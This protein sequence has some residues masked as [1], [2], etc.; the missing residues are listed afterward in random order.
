[1]VE[2]LHATQVGGEGSGAGLV[3]QQKRTLE[4]RNTLLCADL[5]LFGVCRKFHATVPGHPT[6]TTGMC[7]CS[8]APVRAAELGDALP[9]GIIA[10]PLCRSGR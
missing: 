10:T 4:L 5:C 6:L 7:G 1:V 2:S 3:S 8:P 9:R